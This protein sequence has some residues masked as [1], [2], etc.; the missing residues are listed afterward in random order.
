[1]CDSIPDVRL[2]KC[3][4]KTTTLNLPLVLHSILSTS[5]D[6]LGIK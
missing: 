2:V 1:M 6:S 5:L 4:F 3:Q